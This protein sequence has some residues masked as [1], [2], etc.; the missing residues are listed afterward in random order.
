[1]YGGSTGGWEAM[2]VQT[3]YPDFYNGAYI[4]CPD[5]IDF[6][7]YTVI[8]LYKDKNAFYTEGFSGTSGRR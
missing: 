8:D 2:A 7:A 1:V 3:F 5:P 4:A 6:R